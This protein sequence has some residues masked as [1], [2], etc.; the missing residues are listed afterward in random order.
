MKTTRYRI[1][2]R[3]WTMHEYTVEVEAPT[4]RD[5]RGLALAQAGTVVVPERGYITKNQTT[6][7]KKEPTD[8]ES[9]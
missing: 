5:A 7:L 3:R 9:R 8:D 6:I 1:R 2:V 4:E